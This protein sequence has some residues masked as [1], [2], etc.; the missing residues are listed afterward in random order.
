MKGAGSR[1]QQHLHVGTCPPW[2]CLAT[3]AH[4]EPQLD[5]HCI[6]QL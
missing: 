1:Q 5:L 6:S 3:S 2:R 4:I